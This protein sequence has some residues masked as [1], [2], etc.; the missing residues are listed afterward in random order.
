M[1]RSVSDFHEIGKTLKSGGNNGSNLVQDV[2]FSVS[3]DSISLIVGIVKVAFNNLGFKSS[4]GTFKF[5]FVLS[6]SSPLVN[7]GSL[8][9]SELL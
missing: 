2:Q 7:K 1:G 3:L 6:K 9:L 4:G 5:L 8:G